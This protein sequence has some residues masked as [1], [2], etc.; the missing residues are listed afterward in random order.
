MKS[1]NPNNRLLSS[2][3]PVRR[4]TKPICNK[5]KGHI[6]DSRSISCSFKSPVNNSPPTTAFNAAKTTQ[7]KV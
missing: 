2:I 1:M 7:S 3:S 5:A 4:L 6:L